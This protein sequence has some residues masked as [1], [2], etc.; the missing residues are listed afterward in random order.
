MLIIILGARL[1]HRGSETLVDI[2]DSKGRR[3]GS[4]VVDQWTGHL[5]FFDTAGHPTGWGA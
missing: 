4:A 3:T 1:A 2:Y 5:D